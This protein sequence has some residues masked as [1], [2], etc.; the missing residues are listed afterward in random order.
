MSEHKFI[1]DHV[2]NAVLN[3]DINALKKYKKLKGY[4]PDY[5]LLSKLNCPFRNY[6]HLDNAINT[7]QIFN[8]D[9]VY[10]VLTQNKVYFK[11]N[12]TTLQPLRSLDNSMIRASDNKKINIK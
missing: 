4:I 1:R 7:I 12:G 9:I 5:I 2:S 10:G 6:K 11:H 8:L 3:T